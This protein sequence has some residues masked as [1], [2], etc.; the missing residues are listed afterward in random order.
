MKK[1]YSFV[2]VLLIVAGAVL[3]VLKML[4]GLDF[5]NLTTRDFWVFIVL[6]IGLT[7]EFS[8]FITGKN[9]GL[10]IPGGIFTTIGLLFMF[11]VTTNWYF[12]E[13]T[14]PVYILSVAIGLFQM[15]L[16]SGREKG[17]LIASMIIAGISAFFFACMF[18]NTI[19]TFIKPSFFI[20]VALIAAGIAI[21]ASG[22]KTRGQW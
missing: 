1:N 6:L 3:L 7:F 8:F 15:Y 21:F 17:L 22:R 18:M 12:A 2:G 10:L 19:L 16:F 14:W 5:L 13:Y 4:F 11:E 9:S 20:P